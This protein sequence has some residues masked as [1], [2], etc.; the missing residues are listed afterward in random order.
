MTTP[1]ETNWRGTPETARQV[2][3]NIIHDTVVDGYD[4][5]AGPIIAA[6]NNLVKQAADRERRANGTA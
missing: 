2:A 3:Q 6:A 1:S 4:G 5:S